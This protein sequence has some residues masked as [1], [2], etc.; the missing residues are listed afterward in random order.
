[1]SATKRPLVNRVGFPEDLDEFQISVLQQIKTHFGEKI[2]HPKYDDAMLLRFCRAREF[3]FDAICVMLDAHLLWE[4][5]NIANGLWNK[6]YPELRDCLD[7]YPHGYHGCAITG[8]PVF[9]Q[10]I[11]KA[12]LS[13]LLKK[14]PIEYFVEASAQ[15]YERTLALRLPACS[16][17]QGH[18]IDQIVTILDLKGMGIFSFNATVREV[19][20]KL[21]D[22][23]SNHYPE[24]LKK[25]ILVNTPTSFSVVL[26]FLKLI[27][28]E[29]TLGKILVLYSMKDE[30]E[31]KKLQEWVSPDQLP[32]F[33]GGL[34]HYESET[35]WLDNT[36]GPWN[37]EEVI[38]AVSEKD[39]SWANGTSLLKPS[40]F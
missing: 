8:E 24:L 19:L 9:L 34:I 21:N 18:A 6:T 17:E 36:L 30:H 33:L 28:P 3:D 4:E 14:Q 27:L 39:G 12:D 35:A 37:K 26:Q 25:L 32:D 7:L 5:Q 15:N 29:R 2:S 11:G 10:R 40:A 1:M 22:V 13:K 20:K 16:I 23:G 38:A 31:R